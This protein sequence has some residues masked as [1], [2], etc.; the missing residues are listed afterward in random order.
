MWNL[1]AAMGRESRD[2]EWADQ[3]EREFSTYFAS[4][5]ELGRAPNEHAVVLILIR[6][7]RFPRDASSEPRAVP[8]Q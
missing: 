1:H 6:S 2:V 4:K 3:M 7:P 5:P 8:S